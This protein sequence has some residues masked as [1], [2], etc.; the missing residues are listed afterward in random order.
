MND[1]N[2]NLAPTV[3]SL[4]KPTWR[5]L[6]K[7]TE[8]RILLLGIAIALAGLIVMGL[9]A[10]WSPQTSEMMGA[11]SFANLFLGTVVAMSIGYTA[12]YG[13]VLVVPVNMWVETVVVLLFYPVFVLSMRKMVEF[14]RLK[15]YLERTHA[16]AERHHDM[17]RR[18][19]IVGLFLFVWFPFWM[20]GPVV[21][22]VIGYLL[23]FPAWLTLSI[24]LAGTFMT[25][26]GWAY[27]LFG[28]YT[29]AAVFGAWAPV[30]IVGLIIL[31]VLAAY[32]LN[33]R[34]NNHKL[35]VSNN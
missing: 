35:K 15:R 21:G 27:L 31:I 8:G 5:Q 28:L 2:T 12:G 13:H 9:V 23:G 17:V 10:F 26:V 11:M 34:K 4:P 29:S 33:W 1:E 20:T 25:M 14:P 19:G 6:F 32:G 24:V 30:L 7:T 3:E 18:Y 22:S 16:A